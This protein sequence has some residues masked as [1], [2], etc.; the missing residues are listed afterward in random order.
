MERSRSDAPWDNNDVYDA[1]DNK[2]HPLPTRD[3]YIPAAMPMAVN[4]D[5]T[6]Y[7]NETHRGTRLVIRAGTG[8]NINVSFYFSLAI[9]GI[10]RRR[11]IRLEYRQLQQTRHAPE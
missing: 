8:N 9:A 6:G 2:G 1:F 7:N 3:V 4:P 10:D 5:Y 11:R